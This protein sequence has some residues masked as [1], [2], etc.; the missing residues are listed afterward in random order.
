MI[1]YLLRTSPSPSISKN[2]TFR[3]AIYYPTPE[4]YEKLRKLAYEK[5]VS[6]AY[7]IRYALGRVYFDE[8]EQKQGKEGKWRKD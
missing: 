6:M 3:L 5:R 1:G 2:K 8:G 7:L 4:Q